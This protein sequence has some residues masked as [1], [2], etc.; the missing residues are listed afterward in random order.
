MPII[1]ALRT[2][3]NAARFVARGGRPETD[4]GRRS[5]H[6]DLD[7]DSIILSSED[8]ASLC[9]SVEGVGMQPV[10]SK[11]ESSKGLPP[12]SV[13]YPKGHDEM[14]LD[15]LEQKGRE[16]RAR[17]L[18]EVMFR[19]ANALAMFL[20]PRRRDRWWTLAIVD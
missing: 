4:D 10:G 2:V 1:W 5:R 8:E 19:I 13:L 16:E 11:E 7:R 14:R 18:F 9:V 6:T 17:M 15:D 20:E 3:G 12:H